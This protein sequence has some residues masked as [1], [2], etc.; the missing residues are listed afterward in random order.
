MILVSLGIV[1]SAM[2]AKT[3]AKPHQ[4]KGHQRSSPLWAWRRRHRRANIVVRSQP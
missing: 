1:M 2:A 3:K 4:M